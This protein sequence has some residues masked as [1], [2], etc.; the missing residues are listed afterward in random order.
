MR[1]N[2]IGLGLRSLVSILARKPH[3]TYLHGT[4]HDTGTLSNKLNVLQ[5]FK[6]KPRH[7]FEQDVYTNYCTRSNYPNVQNYLGTIEWSVTSKFHAMEDLWPLWTRD[8]LWNQTGV[9]QLAW[10]IAILQ[11]VACSL[12]SCYEVLCL[13]NLAWPFDKEIKLKCK[14]VQRAS[15]GWSDHIN[16]N[17]VDE[18]L[19]QQSAKYMN[20]HPVHLYPF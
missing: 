18:P 7:P 8:L 15:T 12:I 11:S 17:E 6:F 16:S 3:I 9:H 14:H 2:D 4:N 1:S 5:L 20:T 10:S 19:H 13:L